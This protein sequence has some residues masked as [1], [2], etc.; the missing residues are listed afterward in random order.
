VVSMIWFLICGPGRPDQ[1]RMDWAGD[2]CPEAT[3]KLF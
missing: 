2:L 1:G 3:V